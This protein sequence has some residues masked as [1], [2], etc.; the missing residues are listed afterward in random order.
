MT[1]VLCVLGPWAFVLPFS[2]VPLSLCTLGIYFAAIILGPK[3][4]TVSVLLYLLLG[5]IGLPVFTGFIGGPAKLFGPT[6]GYLFGY[7]FIA[8]ICGLFTKHFRGKPVLSFL[9]MCLGTA[10]CYLLGTI[11]LMHQLNISYREALLIGVLP[12]LVLDII[13]ILLAATTGDKLYKAL[14]RARLIN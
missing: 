3:Y 7:I 2:P 6:G 8:F 10:I 1:A 5:M 4:S 9:G 11:W 12:Y 14:L 13:K